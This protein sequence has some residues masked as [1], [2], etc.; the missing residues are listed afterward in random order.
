MLKRTIQYCQSG[1]RQWSSSQEAA[2]YT[3]QSLPPPAFAV[4]EYLVQAVPGLQH[5]D[6]VT[7]AVSMPLSLNDPGRDQRGVVE[8]D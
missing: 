3:K 5:G 6:L 8:K 7:D 4:S 1:F 2:R